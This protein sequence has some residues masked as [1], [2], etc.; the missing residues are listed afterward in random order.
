MIEVSALHHCKPI[1]GFPRA[2]ASVCKSELPPQSFGFKLRGQQWKLHIPQCRA[3]YGYSNSQASL[4]DIVG[5]VTRYEVIALSRH[6]TIASLMNTTG[7]K[8]SKFRFFGWSESLHGDLRC[9]GTHPVIVSGWTSGPLYYFKRD[10]FR[11][12]SVAIKRER[13]TVCRK[14]RMPLLAA[15]SPEHMTP[16]ELRNY[17]LDKL[18]LLSRDK[19][20]PHRSCDR[21]IRQQLHNQ[22]EKE[23]SEWQK[24]QKV[25]QSL[26]K[27][28]RH[29]KSPQPP[30]VLESLR[31]ELKAT[32]TT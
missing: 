31:K 29:L 15:V 4:A 8:G 16:R 21:T 2:M 23:K 28:R 5:E 11:W 9:Y 3:G 27:V 32:L 14:Y 12:L 6:E 17:Q 18:W 20:N 10:V 7:D 22:F 24:L 25:K 30:E 1:P 13:C 26:G 19:E